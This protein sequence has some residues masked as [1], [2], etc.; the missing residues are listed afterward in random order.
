LYTF[1]NAAVS[2]KKNIMRLSTNY[3]MHL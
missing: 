3:I 2:V 1:T